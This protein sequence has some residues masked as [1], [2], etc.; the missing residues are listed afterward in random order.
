MDGEGAAFYIGDNLITSDMRNC[1]R[2]TVFNISEYNPDLLTP[3][4]ATHFATACTAVLFNLLIIVSVFKTRSIQ[5]PSR[6]LL[7]SLSLTDLCLGLIGQPATAFF[8]ISAFNHWLKG[9]CICRFLMT[10]AGYTLGILAFMNLTAMSVDR[11]LAVKTLESYK[12][13]V[14]KRRAFLV[15]LIIW[16]LGIVS[17]VVCVEFFP[18][19]KL[20]ILVVF[21]SL[22]ILTM[23]VSFSLAFNS[24]KTMTNQIF[25]S[26]N[27][28]A[29]NV[30]KYRHSLNTMVY[31]LG[32]NLVVYLPIV[33]L[34]IVKHA[35]DIPRKH[36][37]LAF[38]YNGVLLAI[39]STV[40]PLFYLW[41]MKDLRSAVRRLLS[42]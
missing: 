5:S 18:T 33:V 24:L 20:I 38:Q 36:S 34:I 3:V 17:T 31:I 8:Y 27:S 1:K 2:S 13:L 16:I 37:L 25:D 30:L 42:I 29:F 26:S 19:K 40:N 23:V 22:M 10:R 9:F 41:R 28:T 11:C 6:V 39:N 35:W 32:L 12:T 4:V 21:G 7:C 14:T 15:V